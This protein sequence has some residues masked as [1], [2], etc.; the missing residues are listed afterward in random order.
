LFKY[1]VRK[2]RSL[3]CKLG[4]HRWNQCKSKCMLCGKVKIVPEAQHK[5]DGCICINCHVIRNTLH[6]W[7]NCRCIK[8]YKIRV[9]PENFHKWNQCGVCE[10]C[11]VTKASFNKPEQVIHY[12]GTW[13]SGRGVRT[14]EDKYWP[15]YRL[16]K[17]CGLTEN[18]LMKL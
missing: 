8:C 3:I 13:I 17:K 14:A 9:M 1:Q 7:D 12:W 5:W 10:K 11:S 15:F 18:K 6:E 2:M 16:C 4:I